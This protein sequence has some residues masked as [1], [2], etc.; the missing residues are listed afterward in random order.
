MFRFLVSWCRVS[1]TG[2][3]AGTQQMG[4]TVSEVN[5]TNAGD[6]YPPGRHP[7]SL[8]ALA[9]FQVFLQD[10]RKCTRCNRIAL[11]GKPYCVRHSHGSYRLPDRAG[12]AERRALWQMHNMGLL[13]A[14]LLVHPAWRAIASLPTSVRSPLRLRMVQLWDARDHEPLAFAQAVRQAHQ[15]AQ[16]VVYQ[17][18]RRALDFE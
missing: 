11:R 8:A 15:V 7:A 2:L 13:P 6:K 1:V 14:E 17:G 3:A 4:R 16:S 12:R 5:Q 18:A 10:Q 9:R